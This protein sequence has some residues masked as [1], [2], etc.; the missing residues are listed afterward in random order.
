MERILFT[1]KNKNKIINCSVAILR[2]G[3]LI[4]YP[5]ETCYGAGVD[6]TNPKAVEKLL[7]FKGNRQGKSVSIAVCDKKMAQEYVEL[8]EAAHNLYDHFLPG[9]ITVV[10]KSKGG[11]APFIGSPEGTLG[12]R[13]PDYP[14]VLDI[15]R[16]FGKPI[17]STSA[18]ISGGK[19]P[20]AVSEV[21]NQ[22]SIQQRELI[23]L[24]ID[25]GTLPPRKPSAVVDATLENIKIL[26][27]GEM[28]LENYKFFYSRN[29]NQTRQLAQQIIEEIEPWLGKRLVV[30]QLVG[31]MGSGKTYLTK[32]LGEILGIAQTIVS[33]TFILCNEYKFIYKNKP[34]MMYHLDTHR[35]YSKEEVCGL[36]LEEIFKSPNIVVIEWA[37]KV[38]DMLEKRLKDAIVIQVFLE[39]AAETERRIMYRFNV[40]CQSPPP[41]TDQPLAEND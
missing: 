3:G 10:S 19:T 30:F 20:Y 36:K 41:E 34:L 21:L 38:E 6:P 32:F 4:I 1:S 26:R 16:V 40:K 39:H 27:P 33:P 18:N 35:M 14:L 17:T 2:Q 25:S 23:E 12:V 11:V 5:T 22:L 37:N 31:E 29:E 7:K 13:V 9:P 8:S 24:I 15:I 28:E